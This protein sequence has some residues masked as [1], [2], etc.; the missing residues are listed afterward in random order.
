MVPLEDMPDVLRVRQI[1]GTTIKPGA[2]VRIK[3][4]VYAGDLGQV[5]NA[6]SSW[7]RN[8]RGEGTCELLAVPARVGPPASEQ[9]MTVD[10]VAET[11]TVKLVPR[12]DLLSL[13]DGSTAAATTVRAP[14]RDS[15]LMVLC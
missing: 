1:A 4:G 11:V 5:R 7:R 15:A 13:K 10:E 2:W 14:P 8:R 6:L 9:A 12:L 3:R